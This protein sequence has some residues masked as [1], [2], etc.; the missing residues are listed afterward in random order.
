MCPKI[1][2]PP[3]KNEG[4]V[5]SQNSSPMRIAAAASRRSQY[6]VQR[7][8]LARSSRVIRG[9]QF[10]VSGPKFRR[11]SS[12]GLARLTVDDSSALTKFKTSRGVQNVQHL[13]P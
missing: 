3:P 2:L 1:S 5:P 8:E 6:V 11:V 13:E 7:R 12:S 9:R 10:N 4:P